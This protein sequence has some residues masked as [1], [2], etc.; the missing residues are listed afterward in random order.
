MCRR[1]ALL[2]VFLPVTPAVGQPKKPDPQRIAAAERALTEFG[3][4]LHR[5]DKAPGKPYDLVWFPKK[6][7]DRDA[8]RLFREVRQPGTV[9]MIDLGNTHVTDLSMRELAKLADLES[10]YLDH[11]AITDTGLKELAGLPR[12]VWLD[13]VG[14]KL[15][16]ASVDT[17]AGVKTLSHLFLGAKLD[18]PDV[19]KLTGLGR[20]QSLAL[21]VRDPDAALKEISKLPDLKELRLS[22][23]PTG[24]GYAELAK[25][26][27]LE[28]LQLR[29]GLG[30]IPADGWKTL[31][32][33][34]KLRAL[35]LAVHEQED[36]ATY[37]QWVDDKREQKPKPWPATA[38]GLA[39]L[40]NL[41]CL[42]LT[43]TAI[44]DDALKTIGKLSGLEELYL[45]CT[46][47]SLAGAKESLS[48]LTKLRILK[49]RNSQ[50][51]DAGLRS[52]EGLKSL[53]LLWLVDNRFSEDG[54]NRL[55]KALPRCLV[56]WK[57]G[58]PGDNH[59]FRVPG[60]YG[61]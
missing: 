40:T 37:F 46:H 22:A 42:D 35:D 18:T 25:L 44:G 23:A 55:L 58:K 17:L 33:L 43:G 1:V 19:A 39:T 5:D 28:K 29:S 56:W 59:T 21:T 14:T 24:P 27:G 52:L 12:L 11:T 47:V 30:V 6:T 57:Y 32:E 60:G 45:T 38:D 10:L 31:S 3:C 34:P 54:A 13:L 53:E 49:V 7:G 20:L 4:K 8:A 26:T 9:R 16:A 48:G 36:K 50:V 2:I 41:K 51:A 15:T 61:G